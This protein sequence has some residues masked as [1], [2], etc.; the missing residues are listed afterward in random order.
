MVLIAQ[1]LEYMG[2]YNKKRL[3]YENVSKTP[4]LH[5]AVIDLTNNSETSYSS[6]FLPVQCILVPVCLLHVKFYFCCRRLD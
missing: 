3:Q 1:L 2:E 6:M 5:L 4:L